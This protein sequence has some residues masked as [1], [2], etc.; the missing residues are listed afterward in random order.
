[1]NADPVETKSVLSRVIEDIHQLSGHSLQRNRCDPKGP[2]VRGHDVQ[3]LR[4][5]LSGSGRRRVGR[6][7]LADMVHTTMLLHRVTLW[8]TLLARQMTPRHGQTLA[9]LVVMHYLRIKPEQ[10]PTQQCTAQRDEHF[11]NL[12]NWCKSWHCHPSHALLPL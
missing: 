5:P 7:S 10:R 6:R 3:V 2:S 8:L 12:G 9:V 1:M 11:H 4:L